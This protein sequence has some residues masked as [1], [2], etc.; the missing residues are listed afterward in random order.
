MLPLSFL[1]AH[2]PLIAFGAFMCFA[3]SFG[4]T[5]FIS[6]FG[7]EIRETFDLSHGEFGTVYATGTMLSAATLVWA[8]RLIDRVPLARF[9]AGVLLGLGGTSLLMGVAWSIPALGAAVFG[10]RL[11]GQGLASHTGITA[12]ARYFEAERG[13]VIGIASLGH[14][15]GEFMLPFLVVAAF[16]VIGWRSMWTGTGVALIAVAPLV[17][18]LLRGHGVRDRA[19]Q[20]RRHAEGTGESNK[21]LGGVLRDPGFWLRMPALIAPS[22]IFTGLIFHQVHLA[23]TKGW[24]L[25]LM[26]GSF[27][28]FAVASVVTMVAT[29]PAVDRFSANRLMPLFL[30]PLALACLV[31][32]ATDSPL[33]APLFMALLGL[34]TG[35]SFVMKGALWAELYGTAHLGA[36]R[37]F[38]HAVMVFSTGLAPAVMGLLIDGGASMEAIAM[39]SAVWCAGASA[40]AATAA[41]PAQ[42]VAANVEP[43]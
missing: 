27:S 14:P 22:F 2:G 30:A 24:P 40:L 36:I 3:S 13:R 37:S 26:A 6:L 32:F 8:G 39:A 9:A 15:V 10:L 21:T 1:R 18:L 5:F 16:A 31:L 23:E 12:M 35:V 33:A 28:L 29:G 25:E 38:D 42:Q 43:D 4:Q 41:K 19:L 34:N 7:G 17:F 20:E 11:F